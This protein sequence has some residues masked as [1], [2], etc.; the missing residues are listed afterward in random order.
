MV[1]NWLWRYHLWPTLKWIFLWKIRIYVMQSRGSNNRGHSRFM[2]WKIYQELGLESLKSRRW[3]RRLCCKF[4]IMKGEAPNYLIKLISKSKQ[5]IRTR[6][7]H[8]QVTVVEQIVSSILIQIFFFPLYPKWLAQFRWQHKKL[9]MKFKINFSI[10]KQ[11]I[12]F[13]LSSL[14]QYIQYFWPKR[15]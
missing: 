7:N 13:Y 1:P 11:I 3:Y 9:K 5:T 4:K 8:I 14:E 2:S 6:T 12:I 10:Q 15:P